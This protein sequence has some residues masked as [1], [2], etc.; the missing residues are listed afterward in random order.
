MT[1]PT[2][3]E[4]MQLTQGEPDIPARDGPEDPMYDAKD[5]TRAPA[6]AATPESSGETES[7]PAAESTERE[8]TNLTQSRS[9]EGS[10]PMYDPKDE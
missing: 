3:R 2:E 4:A 5:E 7:V 8:T 1:Q 6:G 9:A 10:E